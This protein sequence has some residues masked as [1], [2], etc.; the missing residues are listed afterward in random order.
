MTAFATVA[1]AREALK[2][3][4]LDYITKPFSARRELA[5]LIA[6]LLRSPARPGCARPRRAPALD[7]VVAASPAMRS[8]LGKLPRVARSSSTV[9]LSGESGT[10]KE[11]LAHAI[12]ELSPRVDRPLVKV[13]C[14]ALTESLLEAELFGVARG[15]FTGADQDR[16]GLFQA[17]D[18]GTLLLD[19]VGELPLSTQAK[20]LRVLQDGEFHRVGDARHPVRVDVRAIAAT[21]RDLERAVEEGA[22][23]TDLFYRLQVV[24]LRVPPLRE[25]PEDVEPLLAAFLEQYAKGERVAVSPEARLALA[26][27]AWPGNVRELENAVEHALVLGDGRTIDV[28]DLPVALQ[29]DARRAG[30][31]PEEGAATLEEIERRCIVQALVKT[32]FHRTRAA[33]LL[34]VTRRA[35]GYRIRKYGLEAELARLAAGARRDTL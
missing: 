26:R 8:I 14:A 35:L 33:Q 24:P 6:D 12:H 17:A 11:V 16:Q 2:R 28:V 31:P 32:R 5:P 25:R 21:N 18:G 1:T 7:G 27:Y 13:N 30:A 34:G 19:E 9:L 10:G 15:A 4:A 3:G 20:L 22:F 23:R 29:D